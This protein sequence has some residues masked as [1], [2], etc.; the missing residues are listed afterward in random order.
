MTKRSVAMVVILSCVTFGIYAL[1]W[2]VKTKNEMNKSAGTTIPTAWLLIVPIANLY[3]IW[4]WS[5]GVEKFTRGKLS[6]VITFILIALLSVIGIAI[7]QSKF[8]ETIDEGQM[9]QAKVA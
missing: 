3:W 7:I 8:N 9:P 5:G 4:Q 1:V 6:Q 2:Y